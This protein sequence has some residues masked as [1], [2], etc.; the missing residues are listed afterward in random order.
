MDCDPF[1]LDDGPF[2]ANVSVIRGAAFSNISEDGGKDEHISISK[3]NNVLKKPKKGALT[4][5]EA[6]CLSMKD[7]VNK[8]SKQRG[9]GGEEDGKHRKNKGKAGDV[10]QGDPMVVNSLSTGSGVYVL[11]DDN[12]TAVSE[13]PIML[14]GD[15]RRKKAEAEHLLEVAKEYGITYTLADG[16]VV[17]RLVVIEDVEVA[18]RDI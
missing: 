10:A 11:F 13:T 4:M 16:R 5:G 12:G 14:M 17:D 3:G 8:G 6:R 2:L 18:N 9:K 7:M 1:D 15:L